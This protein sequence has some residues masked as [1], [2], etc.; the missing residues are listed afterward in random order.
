MLKTC[1]RSDEQKTVLVHSSAMVSRP[2]TNGNHRG[3][4]CD[5]RVALPSN[6]GAPESGL[7]HW[8]LD[9]PKLWGIVTLIAI[10]P[11]FSPKIS[12]GSVWTCL[13]FAQPFHRQRTDEEKTNVQ[14]LPSFAVFKIRPVSL[15]LPSTEMRGYRVLS[16]PKPIL[17]KTPDRTDALRI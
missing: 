2:I 15:P 1:R 7:V 9:H 4:V 17:E 13:V 10:A 11:T 3:G 5:A 14:R 6:P 16:I 12:S 8:I